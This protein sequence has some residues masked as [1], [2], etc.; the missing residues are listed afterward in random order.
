MRI[1]AVDATHDD[2]RAERAVTTALTQRPDRLFVFH[3]AAGAAQRAA[4]R[5]LE[6]RDERYLDEA[7]GWLLAPPGDRPPPRRDDG[8][9][10]IIEVAVVIAAGD[11]T[12][13]PATTRGIELVGVHLCMAVPDLLALAP[14]ELDNAALW[15]GGGK[16][17]S[18]EHARGRAV[19]A[20]GDVCDTGSV[21]VLDVAPGELKVTRLD[22]DGRALETRMAPLGAGSRM[23]VQG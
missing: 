6:E 9:P 8:R 23:Q 11:F 12:P 22:V 2:E 16:E 14:E 5:Q 21:L 19:L 3:A 20:P 15:I 7:A 4:T 1:I 10:R 13:L 17:P 18:W